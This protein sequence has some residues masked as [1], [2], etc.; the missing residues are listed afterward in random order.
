VDNAL[1]HI[2]VTRDVDNAIA[3]D[4]ETLITTNF[5][6]CLRIARILHGVLVNDSQS[7]NVCFGSGF[8]YV[9]DR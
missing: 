5:V 1:A 4:D 8:I 7:K 3:Q 9:V 2:A 6:V